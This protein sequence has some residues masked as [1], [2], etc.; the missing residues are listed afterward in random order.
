MFLKFWIDDVY[1]ASSLRYFLVIF[2]HVLE[3]NSDL[4]F[5]PEGLFKFSQNIS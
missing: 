4:D 2:L 5:N 3:I 1:F